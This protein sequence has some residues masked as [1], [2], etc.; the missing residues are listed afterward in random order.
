MRLAVFALFLVACLAA[1]ATGILFQPG[2]WYAGLVKPGWTPPDAAFPIVWTTI[3]VL[4]AYA[5]S[6]VAVLPRSG[7]AI[8]FWALQ[9]ALNTLWSPVFFGAHRMGL[10][11]GVI[12]ALWVTLAATIVAF[13]RLDRVAAALLL[14][15]LVWI[16][17]AAALN[18]SVWQANPGAG[19]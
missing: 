1:G 12:V 16:S 5:A 7:I 6:R 14:P 2:A 13:W 17:I 9:I 11:F 4:S 3:Y 19:V 8:G 10:G 18:F 15:Y